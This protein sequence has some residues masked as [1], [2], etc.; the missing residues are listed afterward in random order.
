MPRTSTRQGPLPRGQVGIQSFA[1]TTKPGLRS[2]AEGKQTVAS[3]P[4][5]PSKK[6]KLNELENVDCSN[7]RTQEKGEPTTEALTPSKSLRIKELSLSTPRSGH[8][9]S[10][11]RASRTTVAG[12]I[13]AI[14]TS[15]SKRARGK[16]SSRPSAAVLHVRPACVNDLI[17]L[18]SAVLK[19]ITFH[20]AH[21]GAITPADLRE[22]LPSV[23]RLWKKRKVVV[24]DL[25]RLLWIW[26]QD[27][28][29]SGLNYRIANYGLGKVCLERVRREQW[30]IDDNELQEQFEQIVDL[31]WEKALDA[32][33]G[34]EDRVDFITT[35]GVSFIHESLTPFTTF[36]KGQQRL[37]DLKGGVI[38]MKTEKLKAAPV[39][40]ASG[41][42]LDATNARR[43]GLLDR[44]RNKALRQSKLPPP[45]SKETLLRRAAVER[46]EEVAGVLALLRPTGY[47]GSGPTATVAAQRK[48]FRLEMIVQN[49]QDSSKNPISGKEVEICVEVLARAD[50]AGQWID[51]VTVNHIKSVVLKSSADVNLKD[52]GAKAREL[53]LDKDEPASAS[54]P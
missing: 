29:A 36:R 9:A 27:S 45:P 4:I 42:T 37:Q 26:E 48:P 41:K 19:A 15:P 18:H 17:K 51:F 52:I 21:H 14:P 10:P 33:D 30:A 43:T 5:S 24:K 50:I 2:A 11:T 34:D 32:A 8:Y 49:V 40:E 47:I 25:Q 35:L 44:I 28:E 12:E 22:F 53:K 38:K 6:R 16:A 1:R 20:H 54:K 39:E 23:E 3:L 7:P 13:S 31:L 46:I